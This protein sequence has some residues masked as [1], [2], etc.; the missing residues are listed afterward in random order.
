[1]DKSY[2]NSLPD[3]IT[4]LDVSNRGLT[5]LDVRR[6]TNLK[7]LYCQ[8]NHLT[9]L[10]LNKNLEYLYCSNNQ[11]TCLRLNENL[12]RLHCFQNQLTCLNLNKKL[13]ILSCSDNCLTSLRLNEN[14]IELYCDNNQLSSLHLNEELE[15]LYCSFN[16]LTSLYLNKNLQIIH[17]YYNPI[18]EIIGDIEYIDINKIKQKMQILNNFRYLYYCLKFKKR[19]R[20]L[21][22]VKIREPKIKKKYSHSYLLEHLHEDTDLDELLKNW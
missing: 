13:Q 11:L 2:L 16:Q 1:M 15:T 5:S 14:L 3:N 10:Y 21:L 9:C 7:E 19:F 8:H 22:W 20:D 4:K 18:Y 12:Q 6:F 17:Y